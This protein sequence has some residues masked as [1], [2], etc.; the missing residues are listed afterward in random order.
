MGIRSCDR[1][2]FYNARRLY[3]KLAI[4]RLLSCAVK[5][6]HAAGT[7]RQQSFFAHGIGLGLAADKRL[8]KL[9]FP[10]AGAKECTQDKH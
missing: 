6:F 5:A 10:C 4:K 8:G 7:C 3:F 9:R 2:V 1:A